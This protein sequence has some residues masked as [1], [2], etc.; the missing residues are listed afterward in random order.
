MG[1]RT[2]D[3]YVA[4]VSRYQLC[5]APVFSIAKLLYHNN[6]LT[7]SIYTQKIP[8][9]LTKPASLDIILL[10]IS[11]VCGKRRLL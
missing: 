8:L 5:Y 4:N 3:L 10:S 7:A 2:P 1:I 6:L 11:A 9:S